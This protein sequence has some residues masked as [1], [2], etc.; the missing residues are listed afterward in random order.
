MVNYTCLGYNK[1]IEFD[2]I[3]KVFKKRKEVSIILP[4]YNEEKNIEN[5]VD[6]LRKEF[7]GINF[8]IVIVDDNSKDKT[9]KI[10][11][12][13]AKKGN[14]MAL[15]RLT[16]RGYFSAYLDGITIANGKYI[17]TMDS[18]FSH[19][20]KIARE[21]LKYKN[22]YDIVSGSRYMKGGEMDAPFFRKYGSTFLNKLCAFILGLNITDIA[23]DF[24][25]MKKQKF[26]ELEFKYK[27]AFGEFD[28]E[29]LY[30]ANKKGFTIKE[31]PFR[32]NFREE[33]ESAMGGGAAEAIS[34]MKF[35][36]AY[37]KMALKLRFIG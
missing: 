16:E 27:P 12:E 5:L 17:I 29:W 22:K 37:I 14:L 26:N 7:K 11:D 31:I 34:L 8:E 2:N 15:H 36:L 33:G 10:I 23:G 32:Y 35:A 3:K 1:K 30:R 6:K 21:F 25:L 28:F 13:L 4:T 9:P 19:P 20:P 24:H 18:D